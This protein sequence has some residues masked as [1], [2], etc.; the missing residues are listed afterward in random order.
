MS[1]EDSY[2]GGLDVVLYG[3]AMEPHIKVDPFVIPD[4][5]VPTLENQD[6]SYIKSQL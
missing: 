1:K 5:F 6:Y 4:T 2:V 3:I